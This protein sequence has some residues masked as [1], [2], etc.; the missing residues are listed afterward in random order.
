MAKVITVD[1]TKGRRVPSRRC[2]DVSLTQLLKDQA[3][4]ARE[5]LRAV[6]QLEALLV[7]RYGGK[8]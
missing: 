3:E 8:A 2:R 7:A 4:V 6:D 5:L 1:F